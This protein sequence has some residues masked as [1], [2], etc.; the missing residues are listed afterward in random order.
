MADCGEQPGGV[1]VIESGDGVAEID[2]DACGE[3]SC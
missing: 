3:R 1:V 2:G